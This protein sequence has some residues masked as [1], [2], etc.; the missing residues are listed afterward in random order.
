MAIHP[1]EF[2][3][4]TEEMKKVWDTRNKLQKMLEVEAAL[5]EAEAQFNLIPEDMA[6]EIKNK[7]NTKFVTIERVSEIE[8]ET[9]HDITSMVRALAEACN[10]DAGEYVHFG[11]TSNDIIDSSQSML[12][13]DSISIIKRKIVHLCNI[14]L[15]L[16][17][18]HKKT[19][20][21]GR[22]HGQHALPTTYG[23]KFALWADELHRQYQRLGECDERLCVGMMTGA[24]GTSAAL[25]EQGL[26]VHLKVSELLGLPPVLIS[27]QVV[28]RDNHAEFIMD[29]ANVASTL[30]KIAL[31]IRNLQRTEIR[32]LGE[33]FDPEK[34]VGSSTMPHKMNP[35]T[36]ERICGISRVVMAYV[37]TAL[38]NNPLWHERDL[39]N[40]SAERIILPES[41]ILTDYILHLT[42]SL[43]EKLVFYPENIEK[44]LNLTGGLI[45]AERFMAELTRR[46]MGRQTAYS[47]VRECALKANQKE[48]NLEDI[49]LQDADIKRYLSPGE[50]E[51]IMNP[52]TYLGSAVQIVQKV[53]EESSKWF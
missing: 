11:A 22:T 34:Q 25:G 48:V 32:E 1:I 37:T 8:K 12:L 31:E 41:C 53:L 33:S 43:M 19:V 3:Y 38:Q 4:G 51:R 9:N 21:I 52:H 47:L 29:L 17:D 13:K 49:I 24:V 30:D 27:N 5:A 46:G 26:A 40:S 7:A 50:V 42:I 45:M 14:L 6:H 36:A 15:K 39:T 2:R 16:A 35:I 23:M 20:C 28:Q 18:E 44:N 10:G